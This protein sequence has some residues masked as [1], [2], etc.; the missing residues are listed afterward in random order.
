MKLDEAIEIQ[1]Q[2]LRQKETHLSNDLD[3]AIKL[4]IEALRQ[5]KE[6]RFDPSTWEPRPLSGETKD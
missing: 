3:D 4:G 6:S 1:E 5:V 2:Y